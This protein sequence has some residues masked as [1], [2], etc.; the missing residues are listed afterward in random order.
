MHMQIYVHIC[1]IYLSIN[2]KIFLG[3]KFFIKATNRPKLL[4]MMELKV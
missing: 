1:H 4:V 2:L 3:V